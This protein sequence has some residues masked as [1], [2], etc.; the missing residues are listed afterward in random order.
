MSQMKKLFAAASV[1]FTLAALALAGCGS[2]D[3]ATPIVP[4]T[5]VLVHGA[6]ANSASWSKVI[7]LLQARGL[8]VVAVSLNRD[9]LAGDAAIVSRAI[10]SQGNQVVLVA[11]SYGGAVITEAGGADKVKALVYVSAFAP[12]DG[13]SANDQAA[14]YPT[15]AWLTSGVSADQGNYVYLT[16]A[17]MANVFAPDLAAADSAVLAATQGPIFHTLLDGKVTSAAW[18][19]KP[20]WWVYGSADQIIPAPIQQT[21]STRARSQLTVISGASHAALLSPPAEVANVI[22]AAVSSAG[23]L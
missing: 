17:T 15:P 9:T 14:P 13:E 5:V 23:G 4:T 22:L 2:S 10:A 7:P 6:W 3:A 16:D 20:S 8:K 19:T 11:H 1:A 21:E 18:K 12:N